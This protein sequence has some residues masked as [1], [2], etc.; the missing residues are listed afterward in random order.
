M[1]SSHSSSNGFNRSEA[2]HINSTFAQ[3][4]AK[5]SPEEAITAVKANPDDASCWYA[6]GRTLAL[7]G[8]KEKARDCFTRAVALDQS[9][10]NRPGLRRPSAPS[11]LPEWL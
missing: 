8:E 3:L 7:K 1:T 5:T 6:L 11:D 10:K 2:N 4:A 9:I